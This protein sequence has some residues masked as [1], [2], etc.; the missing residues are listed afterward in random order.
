MFLRA[1]YDNASNDGL[2]TVLDSIAM[3]IVSGKGGEGST[4][5]GG[6]GGAINFT[7]AL[8]GLS[9]I[10]SNSNDPDFAPD[11]EALRVFAGDGGNGAT[12]GGTGGSISGLKVANVKNSLGD[13]IPTNLLGSALLQ[14][15]NGGDGGSGDAGA[16]GSITGAKLSVERH[17]TDLTGNL[18]V[19][20]GTGGNSTL[21]KGGIG[22]SILNSSFTAVNGSN[23]DGY[24]LL[25][26][27]GNGGHG[28]KGGGAGGNLTTLTVS[29][30]SLGLSGTDSDLYCAVLVAGNGGDGTGAV[31]SLGGAGG[32]ILGLNQ[33]KDNYSVINLIQA[34]SGG[35]SSTDAAGGVGGSV[36]NVKSSGT[37]GAQIARALPTDPGI[38]QGLFNTIATS[39]LIDTLVPDSHQGVFAGLG[40]SGLAR[41]AN[42][43][44]LNISAPAIAAIGAANISGDFEQAAVVSKIATLLLGYDVD[45]D[46]AH[47]ADDGSVSATKF[48]IAK[49]LI[50]LDPEIVPTASLIARAT[51]FVNP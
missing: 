34:G 44:V 40:G 49:D 32:S 41:G 47:D 4:A 16:G 10:D 15:G 25:L 30:T 43:S 35:D 36:S 51:P 50:S 31:K 13:A 38:R 9:Q 37:L 14:S 12:K 6:N 33:L 42:G 1:D 48:D 39:T 46:G 17:G 7:K 27:T 19:L 2:I 20:T 5:E 28:A 45:N 3:K 26:Q 22:G 23:D 21:G 8:L 11:A 29:S 18:Q 24:G